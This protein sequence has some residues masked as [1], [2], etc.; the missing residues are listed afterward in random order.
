MTTQITSDG[1]GRFSPDDRPGGDSGPANG[2][3]RTD[4]AVVYGVIIGTADGTA[5]G[6]TLTATAPA[7]LVWSQLPADCGPGSTVSGSTLTCAIG[8][9]SVG[10]RSIS[11]A[12]TVARTAAHGTRLAPSL[13][14]VA[15]GQTAVVVQA[16]PVTVSAAPRFDLS[17]NRTVTS[18]TPMT[19]PDGTTPGF[20]IVYPLQL[21][22]D[23]LVD[24]G[25]LLGYEQLQ[26]GITFVDDVSKMY[27]TSASP[28]VLFPVG[29]APPCGVNTGQIGGAPGGRGG[30][31]SNVVDSGTITCTQA[32]PGEPVSVSITGTDT[33]LSSIPT[34]SVTGGQIAGGV[35]PYVVSGYVSLWV[36]RPPLGVSITTTNTY[37]DLQVTSLS[38]QANFA[39]AGEPLENNSADRNIIAAAGISGSM[40]YLGWN[41]DTQTS[42]TQS[43]KYDEPYVT[44]AQALL[45]SATLNNRGLNTWQGTIVCSVFDNTVQTLRE[46]RPGIWAASNRSGITGRPQFAAFDASDPQTARDATCE[47]S[48]MQWHSDPNDVPGGP[49]AVGAV[50]WSFDHVGNN[51]ITFNTHLAV[52]PR[53]ANHVIVRAFTS[54]K[55]SATSAWTHDFNEATG[56]NGP[57][58]DFLSTTSN[59]ARL[60]SAIVDPG[61]TAG[62]TPDETSYIS[63]G[64]P[65]TYA[66]YPT[67]TNASRDRTP[68]AIVITDTLPNGAEYVSGSATIDPVVDEVTVDGVSRQRLTWSLDPVTVN[69]AVEPLTFTVS[70]TKARV[71]TDAV[72]EATIASLRDV[73]SEDKRTTLRSVHVLA[74]SGYELNET[75]D[76][77]VNIVGDEVDFELTYLNVGSLPI[78]SSTLI[79][80]LPHDGDSRGTTTAARP[81][82]SR[83]VPAESG[84]TVRYSSV[85]PDSLSQDPLH[86]SNGA[87]GSTTWCTASQF[88]SK[89]CPKALSNVTGVRIDR[90][91]P[92]A[93]GATV[94]HD[95]TLTSATATRADDLWFS[96][97]SLAVAGVGWSTMS[98][99]AG[100]RVVAGSISGLTW[101]DA[102]ADGTQGDD[103]EA[104]TGAPV[105]LTGTDDRGAAVDST[106]TTDETGGYVFPTLRP[107]DYDVDFGTVP[108]GWT[109]QHAGDDTAADSDVG[110]DGIA[111]VQLATTTER[112]SVIG[113]TE[114]EHIDAGALPAPVVEPPVV[115]P[116]VADPPVADP[117][118]V[119]SGSDAHASTPLPARLA[120]TGAT[121]T[122]L[123]LLV[124]ALGATGLGFIASNRRRA[125]SLDTVGLRPES[126]SNEDD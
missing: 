5:S 62:D 52:K 105:R 102:D 12:G 24:G 65:L 30:G 123:L 37:R 82:L 43:G 51:A 112:A 18:F 98:P 68:E 85:S 10:A 115:E 64:G 119:G 55:R 16:P 88:G 11:L 73:S 40:R 116:P 33:S 91:T 54:V 122:A 77:P 70:L 71:G 63:V 19:G 126:S 117:P 31:E 25:G 41:P 39:G 21:H 103:E 120:F 100:T 72:N 81:V 121:V 35:V 15:D 95:L 42:F 97:F 45:S 110:S 28:A 101:T 106:T 48:D 59:M 26:D 86:A 104:R 69:D 3:V 111:S 23:S 118:V 93:G 74:E 84:E 14:L 107:G 60:R 17:M 78:A 61:H 80:V 94:S 29:D 124:L 4:D 114:A 36:P 76:R 38:G 13:S 67:L 89:G 2:I 75:T 125:A 92:V 90:S 79:S 47:D 32:G 20:R 56:A 27:G 6:G 8:D 87:D 66:L 7:G 22:W 58:A 83:P 109:I 44:P 57:W 113:V 9:V 34:K 99:A 1:I 108:G 96:T 53:L 49:E 50:R 46:N